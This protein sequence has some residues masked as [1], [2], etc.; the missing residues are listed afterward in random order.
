[1][2]QS[3]SLARKIAIGGLFT[4]LS[5]LIQLIGGAIGIG[6]FIA[7]IIAGFCV[8][9]VR[10][11]CGPSYAAVH[12][13]AS[14]LL[15]LM[16]CPD[17]ELAALYLFLLGWYPLLRPLV[18]KLTAAVRWAVRL[19]VFNADVLLLYW[20]LLYVVFDGNWANTGFGGLWMTLAVLV[21]GNVVFF[22]YDYLLSQAETKLFPRFFGRNKKK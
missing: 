9:A 11:S 4:A 13:L 7:P 12:W 21:L 10:L 18:A 22:L 6:T 19:V 2:K 14:G 15:A 16:M 3:V 1:M 17:K 8:E 5:V 20:V